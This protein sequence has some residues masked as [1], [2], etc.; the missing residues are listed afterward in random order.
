MTDD[1]LE[2]RIRQVLAELATVSE[3]EGA[4]VLAY[5]SSAGDEDDIGGRRPRGPALSVAERWHE[6]FGETRDDGRRR[7]LLLLARRELAL[8]R[9]RK[10]TLVD[11]HGQ[12]EDNLAAEG[13]ILDWFEGVQADEA[14]IYESASG[15]FCTGNDIRRIRERNDRDREHGRLM[16]PREARVAYAQRLRASGTSIRKIAME[17]HVA[18]STVQ[19]W[20]KP[21]DQADAGR[22]GKAA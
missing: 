18:T 8:I 12:P 9:R 19:R 1:Q 13:R 11:E 6:R 2:H 14:A 3:A 10:P 16:V 17:M 20:L 21:D 4:S 7:T 15:T 22:R 5:T